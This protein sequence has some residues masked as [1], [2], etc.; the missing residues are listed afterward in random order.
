MFEIDLG[1]PTT[2]YGWPH[3]VDRQ[4]EWGAIAVPVPGA[5]FGLCAAHE[6]WGRLPLAQVIEPAIGAAEAGVRVTWDLILA[7]AGRLKKIEALPNAAALLLRDG[8]PPRLADDGGHPNGPD[9]RIDTSRL[10]KTLHEIAR[11]G[12]AGYYSG[13]VAEAIDEKSPR[14]ATSSQLTTS[15]P[16]GRRSRSNRERGTEAF[17]TPRP[18]MPSA[19]RRSTSL[20]A[21]TSPA[22]AL[23]AASTG[24]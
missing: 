21:S 2:Y 3:A 18:A 11:H 7:I 22:A 14:A 9:E 15:P 24:T 1:Q 20:A 13:W 8:R 19:T 6:R 23:T 16:T 10:A 12:A 17:A 5:V 4:N